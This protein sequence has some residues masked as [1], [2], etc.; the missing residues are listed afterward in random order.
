MIFNT[1]INIILD[2]ENNKVKSGLMLPDE[3]VIAGTSQKRYH[4]IGK[5]L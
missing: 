3:K 1:I 5:R 4:Q 2:M